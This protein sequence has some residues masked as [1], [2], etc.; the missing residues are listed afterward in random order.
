MLITEKEARAKACC[1][2][3]HRN[4]VASRCMAWRELD[5]VRADTEETL[6]YCGLAGEPKLPE[7]EQVLKADA[8]VN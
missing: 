8:S 3:L 5:L 6:G 2:D 7:P 4:C 1:K